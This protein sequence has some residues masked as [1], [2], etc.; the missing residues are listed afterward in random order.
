MLYL[1]PN[2]GLYKHKRTAAT[3]ILVIMISTECRSKKPYALPVQCI[4]YVGISVS[5]M[6]TILNQV[7]SA[8]N[9]RGMDV[10]GV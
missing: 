10:N 6:R 7:V 4:S 2:L 5:Q 3:H 9:D 8:M 1:V